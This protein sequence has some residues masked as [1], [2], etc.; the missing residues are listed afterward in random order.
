[1]EQNSSFM[2]VFEAFLSAKEASEAVQGK[3]S[4]CLSFHINI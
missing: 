4:T 1:M 2:Q 3:S